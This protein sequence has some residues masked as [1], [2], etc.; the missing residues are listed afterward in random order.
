MAFSARTAFSAASS[1]QIGVSRGRRMAS[2]GRLAPALQNALFLISTNQ[3]KLTQQRNKADRHRWL[4]LLAICFSKPA[5]RTD[6]QQCCL[7]KKAKLNRRYLKRLPTIG[8]MI[9][10]GPLVV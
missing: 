1:F 7:P 3:S 6:K 4:R 5:T 2:S 10:L 8:T 9:R